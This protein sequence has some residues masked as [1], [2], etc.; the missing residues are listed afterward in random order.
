MR[1][2]EEA[3]RLGVSVDVLQKS[4]HEVQERLH[5]TKLKGGLTEDGRQQIAAAMKRRWS[6]PGYK[7]DYGQKYKGM[8]GHTDET[9]MK[10]SESVKRKWLEPE[11]RVRCVR[12][13]LSEETKQKISNSIKEKWK[14]PA[15]R[16]HMVSAQV[17][18]PEWRQ[19]MSATIREKWRDPTYSNAVRS[20]LRLRQVSESG[21]NVGWGAMRTE[22]ALRTRVV[23]AA[24]HSV[25]SAQLAAESLEQR[26]TIIA[27]NVRRS[28]EASLKAAKQAVRRAVKSNTADALDLKEILGKDLWFEE[29]VS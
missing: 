19:R 4:R 17:R 20:S 2:V 12:N 25:A 8:R 9:R 14:D 6:Q 29:K 15:F 10:I 7:E 26:Q 16:A 24:N 28:R 27:Q 13:G 18:S 1:K 22:R 11:Y 23:K 5:H 3:A 21:D